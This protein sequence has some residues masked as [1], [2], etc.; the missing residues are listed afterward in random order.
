MCA[1]GCDSAADFGN[2]SGGGSIGSCSKCDWAQE[3]GIE[4]NN[5]NNGKQTKTQKIK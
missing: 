4:H 2:G 3:K 1:F 5:K